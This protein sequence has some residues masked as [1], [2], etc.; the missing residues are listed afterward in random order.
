[1][2]RA[3][4]AVLS[5][6]ALS[7][8]LM[9]VMAV[10]STHPSGQGTFESTAEG[11]LSAKYF[12][13]CYRNKQFDLDPSRSLCGHPIGSLEAPEWIEFVHALSHRCVYS[14][15]VD[16]QTWVIKSWRYISDPQGCWVDT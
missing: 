10:A 14:F 13:A 16:K 7:G 15:L 9:M 2:I 12:E 8:C 11:R 5:M 3:A 4:L 6:L 1:M